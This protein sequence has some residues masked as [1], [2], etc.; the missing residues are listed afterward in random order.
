[1]LDRKKE[2]VK[3]IRN[4]TKPNNHVV[5][6]DR[7]QLV[8]LTMDNH[9]TSVIT[10]IGN[11]LSTKCPGLS[12][13]IYA[14]SDW[15]SDENILDE[16][17]KSIKNARLIFVSMLFMEEH[18]KPI[19]EDLKSKRDNLDA[20]VC[21]M[22]SPEVTRLT[23]MG[24]LDMSKP[25]SG[26]VSFLKRFRNK[27]KSGEEKKPAGE[28]QMR[29]LRS[30]PKIL[31]YIPGTAQDLRVFFL[32]LQYW[33]S[34]SKENIYSLFCM[35]LLKYSKAK[36]SLEEFND[37]YKPPKE[38]PDIG[39]YHPRMRGKISN[40]LSK[41]PRVV[42]EKK[43]KGTV[44]LIVLRSYLLAG[45][46][47]HYDGVIAAFES[48]DIQVI[49]CFSMG[50]DARPAI[51]KFLYSGEEKK[52]DALVSLTGFSLVG[53]PAYND[54][55]AAKSILA[56]LNV[57]YLSASPLEF[58]SLDEWEKSSAGLLPVENTI[59]VAIPELDGA[60][61]PLVFG[62]R[63]VVKGDGELP[64][65]EQD[66]SKTS[67]YLDRNMTF[68]SERVSLLAR[69]VL[70]LIN[71]RKLENRD[72]KVGVVIFNFPPNAV[73][74]GTAAHLDVFS[75]LYNTLLHLKKIGYTVDI[76]K[77]IQELKEKLLEGNSKEYSSDAN[78]VHRTSVDDYVS[79]SRWLSEVEDIWGVAPGK[80]D[81]DGESI[82]VQGLTLGNVFIG[83]QPAFGF[84]GDPMRLLLEKGHAPTHSFCNF[85]KYLRDNFKADVLLHYGTHGALEFMP[86]KQVG[87]SEK[88][89][90]DRLI[91]DLPNFYLY[92]SNNPSEGTLA[93]RRIGA[94]LISY[95]TPP[96]CEAGLYKGLEELHALLDSFY[97]D[98]Q[99]NRVEK[100]EE[101]SQNALI[102]MI[103]D[104]A[105]QL[106]LVE[107]NIDPTVMSTSALFDE[108]GR[109]RSR[110]VECQQTLIPNGL[111]IVGGMK[112]ESEIFDILSAF[113]KNWIE[114]NITLRD[115]N[116]SEEILN[117]IQGNRVSMVSNILRNDTLKNILDWIKDEKFEKIQVEETEKVTIISQ[118]SLLAE[119][120]VRTK[121]LI[122]EDS[123]LVG[124]S[125]ALQGE[126]IE[127]AAGGDLLKNP[128]VLPTGRNIH[129]FDPFRMPSAFATLEGAR[130]ADQILQK[131]VSDSGSLPETIAVVLWGTDNLKTEGSPIGQV[132]HLMG[133]KPR[134]DSYGRL[135]GASLIDLQK[136]GRPR[137]DVMVTLSGIF[138][139]LLPLQIKT[140]AEAA[141]LAA[142]ADEPLE[143]NFIR[144]HALE[145]CKKYNC[146][147][148]T[149][150]LRVFGNSEGTY[151]ANVNHLIENSCWE[152]EEE[153]AN[154]YS[155]RKGFAYGVDGKPVRNELVMENVLRRIDIA[156]QNLDS[157]EVGITTIDTYF[158]TLGG[159]SR[160][161]KKAKGKLN[162]SKVGAS[163]DL[164][165]YIADNTQGTGSIR[166][167]SE[168]VAL[169][170]RTRALNPKWY[171]GMLSHGCEGV[172]QI[173]AQLTHTLGWSATTGQV[174]PWV[175]QQMT[176]TFILDQEMRERISELNPQA[177]SRVVNRLLE[178]SKRKY[179]NPSEKVISSLEKVSQD[180]EDKLEGV[181][182]GVST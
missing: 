99:N 148:Q 168:Q 122:A 182:E 100:F 174:Q 134:F 21:I 180:L 29:M 70:K 176:E 162:Q 48:L 43:K 145:D 153:I 61:S 83:V 82:Y 47:G 107:E 42:P 74:I 177:C 111:H 68:S 151:G 121:D 158:D 124:I 11:E 138:R 139:D 91:D 152:D 71:L 13:R 146:D 85:Y 155:K 113:S 156:Y 38:Y 147:L 88:C 77:N 37:F 117:F 161:V 3:A 131:A 98:V 133:A 30:L 60:I 53:G 10:E 81:T 40:Q 149:A 181:T 89:W 171:E 166:G 112:G 22:S 25:A 123:E 56:K 62:G 51:E 105:R 39:I 130:Q 65:E 59:M 7:E 12:L 14:A 17:K 19:L 170:T 80:I 179:W 169:E 120:L 92:A 175:Y 115:M 160:A 5:S 132:L 1:M 128:D 78:V 90:P 20:L 9:L 164:P 15:A 55:E 129:G 31:K 35:L 126:F 163:D 34:G 101:N 32:S 8:V 140:I 49:P 50:L 157:V 144:A 136:L 72:K 69:K 93:K 41:L 165:V 154:V 16:C 106:D 24:R 33:L 135:A 54:S 116:L 64:Q 86:G 150:A 108:M 173:E 109:L 103:F 45:N 97:N 76:P 79:Q 73:N 18:F 4:N 67:G 127:P 114:S 178:A 96:V 143:K 119:L 142:S 44:G 26:V 172:R 23:K 63:R 58:Q 94:T 104:K 159:I 118:L 102:Q 66:H 87:L 141:F 28:A 57:P 75:S 52:I 84:E 137:I 6:K 167:I 27:G 110:L 36:K 46:T 125:K 2:P 95:M